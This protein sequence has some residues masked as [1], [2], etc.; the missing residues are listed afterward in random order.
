MVRLLSLPSFLISGKSGIFYTDNAIICPCDFIPPFPWPLNFHAAIFESIEVGPL[1]GW[2]VMFPF[3]S[4][5]LIILI[6]GI[7]ASMQELYM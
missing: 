1:S 2:L 3:K 5:H 7:Y 6:S 4:V